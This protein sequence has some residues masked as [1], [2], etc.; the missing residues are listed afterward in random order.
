MEEHIRT[1]K[2]LSDSFAAIGKPV[3]DNEKVFFSSHQP[4]ST[5]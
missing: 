5:I 1:F 4:W 3:S 2:S